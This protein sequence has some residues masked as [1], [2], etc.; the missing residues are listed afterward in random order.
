MRAYLWLLFLWIGTVASACESSSAAASPDVGDLGQM[1]NTAEGKPRA[2]EAVEKADPSTTRRRNPYAGRR[3]WC[4]P[5]D[6]ERLCKTDRDCDGVAH[7][8][9]KK[10]H[11]VR[12]W[13]AERAGTDTK[14]CSPG[15]TNRVERKWR[16]DRL[17]DL[18]SR[19]YFDVGKASEARKADRLERFLWV[20]YERETTA[21]PWKRHRLNGD[22]RM[23]RTAW[24]RQQYRYGWSVTKDRHGQVDE[25]K[26][27]RAIPRRKGEPRGLA[28]CRERTPSPYYPD[29][30]RW[31]FGLGPYG[32]QA[33]LW[34]DDW[35]PLAP[36]EI[37][38]GEVESTETFL[39][40]ARRVWKKLAGG[41]MCDGQI[42]RP[43]PT[44]RDIHRGIA[45][46]KLCP[47][48]RGKD[49]DDFG[50]A[51]RRWGLDPD[52]HVSLAMLGSPIPREQQNERA[53]VLQALL[54]T[55][56]PPPVP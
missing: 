46:G 21:R 41:I 4:E 45:G 27:C 9:H 42:Y 43:S 29:Q 19:Q 26:A 47:A 12:P 25:I 7:P 52:E 2:T 24:F 40:G 22:V 30:D 8:S 31:S 54:D 33:A 15:W 51:A 38:C 3:A 49:K 6:H 48:R 50:K 11:C 14:V 34:T 20:V 1:A 56:L 53:V 23:A 18:L 55:G 10:L 13:W 36:P 17:H 37:L 28:K 39:R 5:M 32:Q 16:R 44:W 35:D